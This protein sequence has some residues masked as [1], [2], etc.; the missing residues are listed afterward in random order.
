[1]KTAKALFEE[2]EEIRFSLTRKRTIRVQSEEPDEPADT[3]Q[4]ATEMPLRRV[5]AER[6]VQVP[7]TDAEALEADQRPT[8]EAQAHRELTR[9]P[10]EA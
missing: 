5:T 3:R 9:G 1:M 8:V 10:S 7:G 2:I 4:E 6:H